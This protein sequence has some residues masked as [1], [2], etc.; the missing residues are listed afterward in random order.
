MKYAEIDISPS[1][2]GTVIDI[3]F[4]QLPCNSVNLIIEKKTIIIIMEIVIFA[5]AKRIKLYYEN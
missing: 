5:I 2:L 4:K 3:N 1:R